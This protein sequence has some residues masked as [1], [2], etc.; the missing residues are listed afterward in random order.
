[1]RSIDAEI[2]REAQ[3]DAYLHIRRR[4]RT[5]AEVLLEKYG[6]SPL[7]NPVAAKQRELDQNFVA[8][9][10]LKHGHLQGGDSKPSTGCG[11]AQ[12]IQAAQTAHSELHKFIHERVAE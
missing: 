7:D 9:S 12:R 5:E 8:M 3:L 2:A 6:P 4:P 10:E 11:V 1:M